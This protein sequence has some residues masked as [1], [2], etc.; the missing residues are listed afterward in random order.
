MARYSAPSESFEVLK[1]CFSEFQSLFT[2]LN[3]IL[4]LQSTST[5]TTFFNKRQESQ[6]L[7]FLRK[8]LRF[9]FVI[10]LLCR[11]SLNHILQQKSGNS[12]APFFEKTS[13]IM[14]RYPYFVT[15]KV[16]ITSSTND[17][18]F[19]IPVVI[20]IRHPHLVTENLQISAS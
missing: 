3:K 10:L 16:E 9:Y 6:E 1:H 17:R 12:G 4:L 19:R 15:E 18:K 14:I 2:F 13:V 5:A 8:Q 7:R 20:L 11:K